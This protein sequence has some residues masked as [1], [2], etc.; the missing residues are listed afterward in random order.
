M[1][2]WKILYDNVMG[3][4]QKYFSIKVTIF[5]NKNIKNIN[6]HHTFNLIILIYK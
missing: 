2:T 3:K 5:K 6:L 1:R 4:K